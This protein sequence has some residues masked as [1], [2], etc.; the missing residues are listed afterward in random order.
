MIRQCFFTGIADFTPLSRT[1]LAEDWV[2]LLNDL[3]TRINSV[4]EGVGT[5]KN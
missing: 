2:S 5:A 1:L 3:F 4:A